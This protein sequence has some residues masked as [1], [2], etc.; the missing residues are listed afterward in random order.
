[1][2]AT[3]AWTIKAASNVIQ[4]GVIV[5][6]VNVPGADENT[7]TFSASADT[8]GDFVELNCDGTNWYVSGLGTSASA[9]TLTVV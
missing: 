5:N 8:V 4:G 7:I 1:M 3:T 6:S 2:F 9:I